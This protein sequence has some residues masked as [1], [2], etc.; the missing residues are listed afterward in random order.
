[1]K[2]AHLT[3][4]FLITGADFLA[5]SHELGIML[6]QLTLHGRELL[7]M[8]G[9]LAVHGRELFV[10]LGQLAV[11][12]SEMAIVRHQLAV[13]LR[14]PAEHVAAECRNRALEC[15]DAFWKLAEPTHLILEYLNTT[16]DWNGRHRGA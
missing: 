8:F 3:A 10:M 12:G 11:H 16:Y 13:H 5:H 15:R 6:G 9:Q 2:D 7:V 14:E 1:M 4:C